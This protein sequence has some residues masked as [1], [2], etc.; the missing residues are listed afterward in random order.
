MKTAHPTG[1]G[2]DSDLRRI[3]LAGLSS[4]FGSYSESKKTAHPTELSFRSGLT[5][6]MKISRFFGLS[7]R[8]ERYFYTQ[9]VYFVGLSSYF[10][11]STACFA[12]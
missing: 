5:V 2:W 1:S 10:D 7:L 8:F 4:R 9:I 11:M 3:H 12:E 6:N